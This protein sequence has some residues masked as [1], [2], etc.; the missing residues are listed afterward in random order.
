MKGETIL[1]FH[2]CTAEDLKEFYPV[3]SKSKKLYDSII[4][5]ADRGFYCLD[6]TDEFKIYGNEV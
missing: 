2:K 4:G 6:W 5:D 1:N 3:A